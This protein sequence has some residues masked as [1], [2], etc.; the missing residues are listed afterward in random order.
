MTLD[1]IAARLHVCWRQLHGP[2]GHIH[3]AAILAAVDRLLDAWNTPPVGADDVCALAHA[4]LDT[5]GEA[6]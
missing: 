5:E 6:A 1:P 3:R 4:V 2:T